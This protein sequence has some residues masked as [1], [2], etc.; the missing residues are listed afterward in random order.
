MSGNSVTGV[1]YGRW[2]SDDGAVEP[3]RFI[4]LLEEQGG[5][6]SGTVSEPDRGG[7]P[8]VH[9]TLRGARS[10]GAIH[11]IKQYDG[12]GP[13]AHA[14]HYSGEVRDDATRIAGTWQFAHYSGAF[15]MERE[16]FSAEELAEEIVLEVPVA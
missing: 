2:A 15:V 16:T 10:G 6:I 5:A 4:A 11:W 7:G 13:F 9:A 14:V 3:N 12:A 8:P 1:W